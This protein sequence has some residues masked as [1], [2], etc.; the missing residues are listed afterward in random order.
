MKTSSNK[1]QIFIPMEIF[2]REF[3]AKTI[4]AFYLNSKGFKVIFGHKWYVTNFALKYANK[5]DVFIEKNAKS[6]K[7]MEYLDILNERH[8]HL[9][10]Y[11]EEA[12]LNYF[13]YPK[14]VTNWYGENGLELFEKW[15]CWGTR[16]FKYLS[17][18]YHNKKINLTGTPRSALWGEFGV[19]FF[20][21][22]VEILKSNYKDY[23]LIATS[24]V[25]QNSSYSRDAIKNAVKGFGQEYLNF[26]EELFNKADQTNYDDKQLEACKHLIKEILEKTD[27]NIV[28]R[29]NALENKSIATRL[30]I[31]KRISID[32]SLSITPLILA[33][34]V[35][36]HFGSTVGIESALFKKPTI[37]LSHLLSNSEDTND[38]GFFTNY[39]NVCSYA[40]RTIDK[41]LKYIINPKI[42]NYS[43]KFKDLV[44][45]AGKF[46]ILENILSEINSLELNRTP[47]EK[48]SFIKKDYRNIIG[49]FFI[50]FKKGDMY[51][52][53]NTKRPLIRLKHVKR[54][55]QRLLELGV[56]EQSEVKIQNIARSTYLLS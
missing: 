44:S 27:L 30:K 23:V 32:R 25:W 47:M 34:K 48:E 21:H 2:S 49:G 14:Y 22:E 19:K 55:F 50:K 37:S 56:I 24:F 9:L 7:G 6:K 12:G 17:K 51:D 38:F 3:Y 54:I 15:L 4:L 42:Y 46:S 53:E 1:I 13:D 10:G 20:E 31:D 5:N 35:V 52:I 43:N 28:I 11:D 16:D 36:V 8:V 18:K 26:A 33:A 41:C 40:P 29:P 45:D 39:S